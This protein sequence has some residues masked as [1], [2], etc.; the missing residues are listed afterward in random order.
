MC[1]P[2]AFLEVA[3]TFSRTWWFWSHIFFFA[4][5]STIIISTLERE[6]CTFWK[7]NSHK[8]R[9][10]LG[11]GAIRIFR[12]LHIFMTPVHFPTYFWRAWRLFSFYVWNEGVQTINHPDYPVIAFF[13]WRMWS[14]WCLHVF[15]ANST[16]KC[17]WFVKQNEKMLTLWLPCLSKLKIKFAK[18]Q[19]HEHHH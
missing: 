13:C 1:V 18:K 11:L 2:Y 12:L 17:E 9:S 5:L 16:L 8:C 4:D 6:Q 15:L 14:A 3:N 10:H 7:H 19:L